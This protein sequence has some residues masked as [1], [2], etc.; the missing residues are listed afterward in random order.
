MKKLTLITNDKLQGAIR[1]FLFFVGSLLSMVFPEIGAFETPD[2][3]IMV[4]HVMQIYSLIAGIISKNG[5]LIESIMSVV[6]KAV[7]LAGLIVV[8][9]LQLVTPENWNNI[10]EMVFKVLMILTTI[11]SST[12]SHRD[13]VLKENIIE[14]DFNEKKKLLK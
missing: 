9:H 10:T 3:S 12:L 5:N 14:M 7:T 13:K 11:L 1:D 8:T 4:G 6:R 2:W